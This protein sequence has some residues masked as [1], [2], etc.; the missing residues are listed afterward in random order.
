[1]NYI[2]ISLCIS[3]FEYLV[4][5]G[6]VEAL[7]SENII[8]GFYGDIQNFPYQVTLYSSLGQ[9]AGGI[10]SDQF[11]ISA[12]H[13]VVD[14]NNLKVSSVTVYGGV[15]DLDEDEDSEFYVEYHVQE[16]YYPKKYI[17]D[18]SDSFKADIAVLKIYETFDFLNNPHTQILELPSNEHRLKNYIGKI[19]VLASFGVQKLIGKP[20][21]DHENEL[22][23]NGSALRRLHYSNVKILSKRLCEFY[24]GYGDSGS[25]LV[26]N[27]TIIGVLSVGPMDCDES[28]DTSIYVDVMHHTKFIEN[29]LNKFLV[30]ALKSENIIGGYDGDVKNFPYQVTISSDRGIC[31][32]GIISDKFIISAAHCVIDKETL[33]V[34]KVTIIGGITDMDKDK[35]SEF[36][37]KCHVEKF[38]FLQEYFLN[39]RLPYVADIVVLKISEAFDFSKNPNTQKLKLSSNGDNLEDYI[40]KTAVLASFGIHN[41]SHRPYFDSENKLNHGGS[42]SRALHYSKAKVLSQ[43]LCKFYSS[44]I[45]E[46]QF[47]A[48]L[49]TTGTDSKG[50]PDGTCYGDS[51]SPLV[52]DNTIIGVLSVGSTYCDETLHASVYINVMHYKDFIENALSGYCDPNSMYCEILP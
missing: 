43:K 47:C 17:R 11:I 4:L 38:Y 14:K 39:G 31:G 37:V 34:S 16:Y 9:C 30:K 7:Q 24:E 8:G 19:A 12:A 48:R 3:I 1:M 33:E 26:Y 49:F 23:I 50:F 45:K 2:D 28:L 18:T 36:H 44:K 15:T 52:Y 29:A 46:D 51:G 6:K 27:N 40:E 32:G 22:Q 20:Y 25:P 35:D 42:P 41:L 5:F 13:C 21:L 10:I